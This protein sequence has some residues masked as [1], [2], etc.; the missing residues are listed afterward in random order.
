MPCAR[1]QTV[2]LL[3]LLD[4][5]QWIIYHPQDSAGIYQIDLGCN[6]LPHPIYFWA[7]FYLYALSASDGVLL[8]LA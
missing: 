5:Y 6:L 4:C 1:S 8:Q 2:L 7:V 3:A